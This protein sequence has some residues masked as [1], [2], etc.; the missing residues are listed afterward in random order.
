MVATIVGARRFGGAI[1]A[2]ESGLA[3]TH[4]TLAPSITVTFGAR[5]I[6]SASGA[7]KGNVARSTDETRLAEALVEHARALA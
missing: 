4:A 5:I 2:L 3:L 7:R 6:F 1:I